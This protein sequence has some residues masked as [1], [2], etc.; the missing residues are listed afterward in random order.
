MGPEIARARRR[1]WADV[2]LIV[3][4]VY[5]LGAAIWVPPEIVSGGAE[6]VSV[7]GWLQGAYALAGIIG[8]A[9][10]FIAH[11][12]RVIARLLVPI[13]GLVLLAGFFALREITVLSVV[14]L[15]LPA[16]AMLVAAGFVGPMPTP[17]EEG[18]PRQHP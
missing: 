4:S 10:L 1:L 11:R 14:S 3:A 15:G 5:A 18:K 16:L 9:A 17:E 2:L 12:W 7:P 6:E 13:A 8:I